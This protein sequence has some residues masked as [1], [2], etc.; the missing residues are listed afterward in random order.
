MEYVMVTLETSD[1]SFS[2]DF[3]LPG[4]LPI[5]QFAEQL[6]ETLNEIASSSARWRNPIQLK[7]GNTVLDVDRSLSDYGLWDGSIITIGG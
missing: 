4:E 5:S 1:K 6:A 2:A 3:E 7:K